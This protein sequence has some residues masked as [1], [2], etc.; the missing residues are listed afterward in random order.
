MDQQDN[1][2]NEH[3]NEEGTS[4]DQTNQNIDADAEFGAVSNQLID[5]LVDTTL[6]KYDVK[7][8]STALDEDTKKQLKSLVD[9]LEKS[10]HS[11]RNKNK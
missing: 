1:S 10:V 5:L 2:Q 7:L 3:L 4:Q 11:L 8:E 9:E 6:K